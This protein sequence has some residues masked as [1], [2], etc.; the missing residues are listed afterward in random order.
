MASEIDCDPRALPWAV[1]GTRLRAGTRLHD[2]P[3]GPLLVDGATGLRL[4]LGPDAAAILRGLPDLAPGDPS[5]D[6]FLRRLE[7]LGLLEP[8]KA[9]DAARAQGRYILEVAEEAERPRVRS[10]VMRAASAVPLHRE[11]LA[12]L[13]E[14][15]PGWE[16][17][18]L[19]LLGKDDL[20]R[21]F[22]DGLTPAGLDVAPLL[23]RRDLVV[24]TTSG[25]T[26]QRLQVYSDT[27]IERLPDDVLSLW[28]LDDG[29]RCG[30]VRTVVL[31]SP[32]CSEA[33]C[34][35]LERQDRVSFEHTLFVA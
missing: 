8:A 1:R 19:P 31:T 22:P 17:E 13:L 26:D 29:D 16:L 21:H 5:V 25:T 18:N 3:A 15:T 20:R 7:A 12:S 9:K 33:T 4:G 2:G 35:D 10:T 23:R 32:A 6:M 11:R 30:P 27:R 24:A 28:R 34:G 14:L